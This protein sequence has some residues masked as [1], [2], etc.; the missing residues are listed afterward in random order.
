MLPY[1][2]SVPLVVFHTPVNSDKSIH[3]AADCDRVSGELNIPLVYSIIAYESIFPQKVFVQ[4][5][6]YIISRNRLFINV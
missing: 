3:E 4:I 1:A 6:G 2:T 5:S